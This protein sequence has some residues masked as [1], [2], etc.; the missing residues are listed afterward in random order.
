MQSPKPAILRLAL[1]AALLSVSLTVRAAIES[2][3]DDQIY[4]GGAGNGW[5]GGWQHSV[6]TPA[7]QTENQID[8]TS[9]YIRLDTTGATIRNFMRQFETGG[10]VDPAAPYYIRWKFRLVE[11]DFDLNFTAN[12]DR[13]HFFGR[14]AQRL[15]GSTD[16]SINW[17]IVAAGAVNAG[18]WGGKTFWIFDNVEGNGTFNAANHVDTLIP[19]TPGNIYAFEVFVDPEQ[20]T[21][22]VA[23]TNETTST[24]FRSVS[25]PA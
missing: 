9:P 13:V 6:G 3:F 8:G 7:I 10:G 19:L 2:N 14:N 17:S 18:A 4:P 1:G 20:L 21:F 12:T 11:V 16:A 22:S 5:V 15:A 24:S 23:I 25:P